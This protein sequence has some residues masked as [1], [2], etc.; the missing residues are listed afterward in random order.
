[1]LVI[2]T[3]REVHSAGCLA[4]DLLE[5]GSRD[6]RHAFGRRNRPAVGRPARGTTAHDED[7]E[8][9]ASPKS[10]SR[11]IRLV[12]HAPYTPEVAVETCGCSVP[13]EGR[14]LLSVIRRRIRR[15]V[16]AHVRHVDVD[17]RRRVCAAVAMLT[18]A[19]LRP[20]VGLQPGTVVIGIDDVFNDQNMA[21][22]T[23][24]SRSLRMHDAWCPDLYEH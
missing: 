8:G 2:R 14:L 12:V 21:P 18:E 17:L 23:S 13:T 19:A 3:Q 1:M 20:Q 6:E 4:H 22:A 15:N 5:C 24:W 10:S 7:D 11:L 16:E 9:E